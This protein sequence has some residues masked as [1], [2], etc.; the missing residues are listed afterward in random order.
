ML[1]KSFAESELVLGLIGAVG[2]ELD[3]IRRELESRL[4]VIGYEVLHVKITEDVIPLLVN[5]KSW[6]KKDHHA[7]IT[8]LMDAGNRAREISNDN[9]ILALGAAAFISRKRPAIHANQKQKPHRSKQAYIISS[10]K[11]PEEVAR[12]RAI[13]PQGFYLIG[14]HDDYERRLNFLTHD[15]QID[16]T[17]AKKLIERDADEHL[18]HGQRVVDTFHL[19]DFFVRNDGEEVGLKKSLWRLL[20]LLFGHP[21]V[22]PTFDEY[23]MFLAFSSSL[24]SADLS[25]QVG[26]V[27]AVDE[28]IIA[29]GANDCPRAGG[30]QYWPEADKMPLDI[31]FPADGRDFAKGFDTNKREQ[32]KIIDQILDEA[33]SLGVPREAMTDAIRTCRIRDLTEFGRVVHAE[34]DALLSCARG[35]IST[36]RGTLYSTTLPCHNCAKHIISAGIKKVIFIEPYQKSKAQEFHEDSI[37]IGFNA[38][39]AVTDDPR[40]MVHFEPFV[41]VGPRRFFDLFSVQ[42]GSGYPVERKNKGDGTRLDWKPENGTLR[43]QMLPASYLDLEII[44]SDMFNEHRL[45]KEAHDGT[46]TRKKSKRIKGKKVKRI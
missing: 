7:R 9:S 24:R 15:K 27:I 21:Y 12:L 35:Q 26:C 18:P 33:V 41:G 39:S 31:Q 3:Q 2:T 45:S 19:S 38:N 43:L 37:R 4:K 40:P 14:V 11:H 34:M 32:Q 10:I 46:K 8:S 29:T 25:R 42:L 22:T 6:N 16:E 44:A 1:E 13:Y 17:L 5:P 20:G 28:R 23:A 36:L 30:G